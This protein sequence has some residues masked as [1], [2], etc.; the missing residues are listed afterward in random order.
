[1]EF[2]SPLVTVIIPTIAIKE[3]ELLLRRAVESIRRSAAHPVKIIAVV[4]GNRAD[5]QL[6]EWLASEP[7]IRIEYQSAPSCPLAILRGRELVDTTFFSFLDDDDEYLDGATDMK[8]AAIV[9]SPEIDLVVTDGYRQ[10]N[11]FVEQVFPAIEQVPFAPL[12]RLFDANWLAS[13]NSL[14]RTS[15]FPLSFFSDYHKYA[16]WTWLAFKLSLANKRIVAISQPTFRIHDTPGSLSKSSDYFDAF[17]SLYDRMIAMTPPKDVVRHIKV[18]MSAN[19]HV[20]SVRALSRGNRLA[21]IRY[22]LRSILLFGGHKYWAYSR[23]LI[24]G[25]PNGIG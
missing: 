6:C 19:W 4:N 1:M 17:Q 7:D 3:K 25:W 24:P 18:R 12:H 11:S 2:R 20:Q 13:C 21:A 15:S 9:S 23:R 16:E 14:F 22:H 10:N 8:I 5:P